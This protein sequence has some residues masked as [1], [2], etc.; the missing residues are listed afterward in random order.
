LIIYQKDNKLNVEDI[1]KRILN[2]N[3]K[4]HK[5][6]QRTGYLA[7][8]YKNLAKIDYI[9]GNSF[10]KNID[11]AIN[12]AVKSQKKDF[13]L[14]VLLTQ[15]ILLK[16]TNQDISLLLIKIKEELRNAVHMAC[17]IE[18]HIVAGNISQAT[19]LI[20]KY[21]FLSKRKLLETIAKN[22]KG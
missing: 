7:L 4:Y 3:L 12:E 8:N 5:K 18:Y 17:E 14:E 9:K 10:S 6:A 19:H 16:L 1:E 15:A 2:E 11:L 20:D 21:S 22:K 13:E